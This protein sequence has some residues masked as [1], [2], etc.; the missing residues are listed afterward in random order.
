LNYT[1]SLSFHIN[2]CRGR[3]G[4]LTIS[5]H[6]TR[7]AAFNW[8]WLGQQRHFLLWHP[9]PT[10]WARE[11]GALRQ[12]RYKSETGLKNEVFKSAAVVIFLAL[13]RL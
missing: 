10:F 4:G 1:Q 9:P 7:K 5:L 8:K 11:A 6:A 13:A 2:Y 3:K 12:V